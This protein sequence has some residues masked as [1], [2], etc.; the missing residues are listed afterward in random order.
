MIS[1]PPLHFSNPWISA[2]LSLPLTL[3]DRLKNSR[4]GAIKTQH[5]HKHVLWRDAAACI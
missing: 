1:N 2:F 4:L 5:K 3:N